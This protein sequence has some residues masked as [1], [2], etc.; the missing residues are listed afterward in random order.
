MKIFRV[1][2]AGPK[3]FR[4]RRDQIVTKM[5]FL[6]FLYFLAS[7][8]SKHHQILHTATWPIYLKFDRLEKFLR[9][10]AFDPQLIYKS[11][12]RPPFDQIF[13]PFLIG[14]VGKLSVKSVCRFFS[15]LRPRV[16]RGANLSK[17]LSRFT[18]CPGTNK[19]PTPSKSDFKKKTISSERAKDF[20][21][22]HIFYFIWVITKLKRKRW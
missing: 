13:S 19:Q 21:N 22:K 14:N 10:S 9:G 5:W 17:P 7:K 11:W 16:S 15:I 18:L 4:S 1:N 3:I 8:I 6:V 20:R 2:S 12:L